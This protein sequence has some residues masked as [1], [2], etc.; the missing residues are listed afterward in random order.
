VLTPDAPETRDLLIA[1]ELNSDGTF[2][3]H[4]LHS[5]SLKKAPGAPAGT[6]KVTFTSALADQTQGGQVQVVELPSPITLKAEPNEITLEM[7]K[8]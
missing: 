1:A 5:V 2:E 4:T 7:G 6:Y 3:L 8:K